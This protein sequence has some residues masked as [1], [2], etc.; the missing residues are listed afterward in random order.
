VLLLPFS[1]VS[2]GPF[3]SL[4]DG[5][6]VDVEDAIAQMKQSWIIAMCVVGT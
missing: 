6:L 1:Y 4:K 3:S 2:A 5:R